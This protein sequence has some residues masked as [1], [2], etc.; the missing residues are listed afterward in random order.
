[1]VPK[2][3][4]SSVYETNQPHPLWPTADSIPTY[5]K[6]EVRKWKCAVGTQAGLKLAS[7]DLYLWGQILMTLYC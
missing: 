2:S 1:M 3:P 4:F 7:F 6:I 5:P